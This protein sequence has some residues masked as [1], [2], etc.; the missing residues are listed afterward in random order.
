LKHVAARASL[1]LGFEGVFLVASGY[2]SV[3]ILAWNLEPAEFGLYGVIIS[4]LAWLERT[5]M[6]GIP[7][8]VTKLTAE[9][10]KVVT[11]SIVISLALVAA[12]TVAVWLLAPAIARWFQEPGQE[13]LFRLAAFDIPF[14]G[15]YLLYRGMAMGQREF[16]RAFASGLILGS[17]KVIA[18]VWIILAGH[19]LSGA[20]VAYIAG[21]AAACIFLAVQSPI[22]R[23]FKGLPAARTIIKIAWPLAISSVGL[24]MVHSL[25][26]WLLK[27]LTA[28]DLDREVGVYA[29]TRVLARSPEL[30]LL[31]LGSV[32]FP[33][34]SRSLTQ[35]QLLEVGNYIQGAMRVLW[36]VLLPTVVLVAIDA[37]PIV[38]LIFP[39]SYAGGGTVLG[40]QTLGFGLLTIIGTLLLLL[41]ARGDLYT[42]V[43]V[44][45]A[46]VVLL[47]IL[48][49]PLIPRY[50]AIGA[51]ITFAGTAAVGTIVFAVLVYRRFGVL[52]SRSVLLNGI[53]ATGALVLPAV[54]VSVHGL[55]L[56][57]KY[58]AIALLY[59]GVLW[60][61]GELRR[62]D[63]Q[64]LLS[65][66]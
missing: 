64:L 66:R 35:N 17:I 10:E 16:T 21:S 23:P 19:R 8:A 65:W 29:A 49:W 58:A 45:L 20:L 2:V 44:G 25:D 37:E 11:T 22:E 62:K 51:G 13:A 39:T 59:A 31:P 32:L 61:V 6:L 43:A 40:L 60:A 26:L 52:I 1:Q 27:A 56:I 63:V 4:L 24:S 28:S 47:I 14:Y 48:A 42:P 57:P 30:V 53:V 41:S 55:W 33:L 12:M 54:T 46:M 3:L 9:G 18:L 38:R 5:T 15:M 7:N 50:G 36:L 34:V